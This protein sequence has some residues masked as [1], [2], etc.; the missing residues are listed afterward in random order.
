VKAVRPVFPVLTTFAASLDRSIRWKMA[1]LTD[2]IRETYEAA[3][4]IPPE[5]RSP[6]V[7]KYIEDLKPV[8]GKRVRR[9]KRE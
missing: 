5:E 2:Q 9:R 1:I 8:L 7:I 6:G 3:L 4:K